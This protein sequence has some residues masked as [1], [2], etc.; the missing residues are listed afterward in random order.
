MKD[1]KYILYLILAIG[2]FVTFKLL[3]PKQYNW[4]VT[5]D[6]ED[7]NPF[8]GYVLKETLPD[9]L[10]KGNI[11]HSNQT[12]Y[13][14]KDSLNRD[15]S[16]F[17]VCSQFSAD[18]LDVLALLRYVEKGGTA[19]ISANYF[20]G[21]LADTLS[22]DSR[23]IGGYY[24]NN[25]DSVNFHFVNLALDT[26]QYFRFREMNVDKYFHDFDS[27]RTSAIS[28]TSDLKTN[29]ILVKWGDGKI[30]LNNTPLVFSNIYLME[31]SNHKFASTLLS[32]MPEGPM[33]WSSYYQNG[34]KELATPL[35]YVLSNDALSWAYYL[36]II[37]ILIF[38]IFEFKRKQRIIPIIKP[39][40]NVSLEYIQTIGSLYYDQG[41]HKGLAMKK[42]QFFLDH[43][44]SKFFV[45]SDT[46]DNQWINLV[47][48][49]S[50][51]D[52]ALIED[53]VGEIRKVQKAPQISED[54]LIRVAHKIE[55]FNRAAKLR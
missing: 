12:L 19:F 43:I 16:L 27:L 10:G 5:F 7:K 14:I 4:T 33:E 21:L 9:L 49:K 37:S 2:V 34:R 39:L 53:L 52:V 11:N 44:R 23:S 31:P 47:S 6:P 46:L 26:A 24:Y 38:M 35:R 20:Y 51:V 17:I 50:G 42:I 15:G 45:I 13:E 55:I 1:W 48:K 30:I 41:D 28:E 40:P 8:G 3:S 29:T 36:T 54:H 25:F 32:Y 18:R 22:I